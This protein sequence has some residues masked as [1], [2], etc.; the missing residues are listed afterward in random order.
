MLLWI[1]FVGAHAARVQTTDLT[2]CIPLSIV[3]RETNSGWLSL[4]VANVVTEILVFLIFEADFSAVE[5]FPEI[6][7]FKIIDLH[8]GKNTG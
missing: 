6:H 7:E 3:A 4:A 2:S 8:S 5:I 1:I